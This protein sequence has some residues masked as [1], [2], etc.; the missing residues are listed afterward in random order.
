M[1]SPWRERL[2]LPALA[3]A[4]ALLLSGIDLGTRAQVARNEQHAADRVLLDTLTLPDSARATLEPDGVSADTTL[5]GLRAPQRIYLARIDGR[6]A[7]VLVPVVA[8]DGFGGDIELLVGVAAD[9]RVAG[10]RVLRHHESPDFGAV[11]ESGD[12]MKQFVDQSLARTPAEQWRVKDDGGAFDQITGA[13]ITSRAVVDAVKR[14]LL[15]VTE[16]RDE[17]LRE[18]A[19]D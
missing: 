1:T 3:L 9:G 12:W 15:Y 4:G 7:A 14:A 6:V 13:T 5:L 2:L 19:H 17:L 11:I 16:H 18:N 8:R 10:V